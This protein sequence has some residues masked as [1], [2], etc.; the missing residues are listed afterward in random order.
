MIGYY[1]SIYVIV[2]ILNILLVKAWLVTKN[3]Y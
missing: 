3:I 1:V 2:R